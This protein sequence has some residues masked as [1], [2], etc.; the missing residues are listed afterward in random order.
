[1]KRILVPTDFSYASESALKLASSIADKTGAEI[2][3]INFTEHPYDESFSTAG[4]LRTKYDD[5]EAIFTI[6]LI[7]RNTQKL[8]ELAE[9]YTEGRVINIQVYGEDL[10]DGVEKFISERNI[11][12]VVMGTT[13]QETAREFFT[14]NH[15]EQIIVK[16]PI[17]VLTL[18]EGQEN[19]SFENL[20]VGIELESDG[21]DNFRAA[22]TYLRNF[23]SDLGMK[24]HLVH[25][26]KP[27]SKNRDEIEARLNEFADKFDIENHTVSLHYADDI[28]S[29]LI[30]FG[31][32]NEADILAVLSHAEGGFFRIFTASVS[33]ELSKES[34]VPLLSINLHNV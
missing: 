16:S 20:V 34:E 14:G 21:K 10:V 30:R 25:I 13:G 1:M 12:L 23:A 33:E 5:E 3:L 17:P 6:Q 11:D 26:A 7:R 32:L 31:R 27:G 2:F 8:E 28:E 24:L 18:R 9:R 4:D 19:V 15:T 22:T 29:G